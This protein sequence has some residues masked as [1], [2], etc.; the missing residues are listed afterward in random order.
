M[1]YMAARGGSK[2]AENNL[3]NRSERGL[4]EDCVLFTSSLRFYGSRV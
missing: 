2:G 4:P 1:I 3:N